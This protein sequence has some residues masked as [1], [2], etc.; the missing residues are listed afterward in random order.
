MV[1][2]ITT[3][4]L[5]L[6]LI[7]VP[8]SAQQLFDFLGQADVPDAVGGTLSMH[9]IMPEVSPPVYPPLPLDFDNFE[10]TLVVT[11]LGLDDLGVGTYPLQTYSGG[12]IAIYEDAGTA[13][14][15]ANPG[16]FTDGTA[17]LVGNV[18]L[19]TRQVFTATI[20]S[21]A[22]S[23]DWTGGTQLNEFAPVDQL[24][25]SFLS[26]INQNNA[27]PGYDEQWDGK[28]EPQGPIV[29]T[30]SQSWGTFKAFM[31]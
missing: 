15:Y 4:L 18:T 5:A 7:A 9:S 11:G 23:V 20:G 10:Y 19:L 22:G 16:T 31:R 8:A 1:T 21:I 17:I 14:D 2:K 12:T 27:E 3:L 25:W 6:V 28:V 24:N 29:E 30:E 26:G 13:A